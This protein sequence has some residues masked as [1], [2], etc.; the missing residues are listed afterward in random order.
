MALLPLT[1]VY[2]TVKQKIHVLRYFFIF[3]T[4]YEQVFG[5]EL[6]ITNSYVKLLRLPPQKMVFP[7]ISFVA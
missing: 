4:H 2:H 3:F 1:R 6:Y 7:K 5:L